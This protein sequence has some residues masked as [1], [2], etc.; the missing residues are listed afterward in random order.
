MDRI[1]LALS[2]W[3]GTIRGD[4]SEDIRG[5]SDKLPDSQSNRVIKINEEKIQ[6]YPSRD[7]NN[8]SIYKV[9]TPKDNPDV[10]EVV[11]KNGVKERQ[12]KYKEYKIF[13]D[14]ECTCPDYSFNCDEH[15]YCKHIWK[16]R[17]GVK[18]N[19]LPEDIPEDV[20]SWTIG[21]IKKD[22]EYVNKELPRDLEEELENII[23]INII[24]KR[25]KEILEKL[26]KSE[27]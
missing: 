8:F 4:L 7:Q 14:E 27:L 11:T 21:E 20:I 5:L 23:D 18:N 3:E 1:K 9:R 25:R 15:M 22:F 13:E 24:H 6:L 17:L 16:K 26:L 19:I 10:E 12:I 2:F